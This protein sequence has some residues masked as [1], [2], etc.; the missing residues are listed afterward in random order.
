MIYGP[1]GI[2]KST[3][4]SK[5][6]NPI[7]IDTEDGTSHLDVQ[8]ASLSDYSSLCKVLDTVR[9]SELP[10]RT[11]VIDTIDYVELFLRETVCK[12]HRISG[13]EGLTYG[14]AYGFLIE[15]FSEF[16]LKY[17]DALIS[18]GIHVLI[19]GHAVTKRIQPPGMDAFDRWELRLYQGCAHRIR[20][21]AD[22]VLFLNWEMRV[23]ENQG[24]PKGVGGKERVI[25]TRHSAAHDAKVR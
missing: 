10:C 13:M 16:L 22:H 6:P 18:D 12:E 2:G 14:K 7:F 23:T 25:Y 8:R 1:N 19:V 17:L 21:W 11:L 9:E 5:F 15:K 20:E 4:A 3:L 24:R